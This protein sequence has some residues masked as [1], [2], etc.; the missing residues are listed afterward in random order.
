MLNTRFFKAATAAMMLSGAVAWGAAPAQAHSTASTTARVHGHS[1]VTWERMYIDWLLTDESNALL[2]RACGEVVDGVY[3]LPASSSADATIDCEVPRG[4]P[5]LVSPVGAFSERPTWGHTDKAVM[6]DAKATFDLHTSASVTVDGKHV[7]LKGTRVN[8]GVYNIGPVE[9]GSFFD[10]YC[11]DLTDPCIRDWDA[12]D[13]VRLASIGK[14]VMIHPLSP[15]THVIT[16]FA[17]YPFAD[18]SLTATLHVPRHR[19]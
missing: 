12:G 17:S 5:V 10:V 7:S 4:T 16:A 18:Y 1:M 11:D 9:A 6:A 15:G 13:T 14:Y 3:F 2:T 19:S 8:A